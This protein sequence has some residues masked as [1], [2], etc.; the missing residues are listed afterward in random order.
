[1]HTRI[2]RI[3]LLLIVVSACLT[4]FAQNVVVSQDIELR[5]D[6]RYELFAGAEG[7]VILYR[8]DPQKVLLDAFG[9]TLEEVW[10]RELQLDKGRPKPLG[11]VV[12]E[13]EVNV[14]YTY[15]KDRSLQLKMHRYSAR[16]NMTDS[17]TIMELK[18]DFAN[19]NYL[20]QTD[21]K[22]QYA[23]LSI[24][25]D[26]N[27]YAM[28]GIEIATGRVLYQQKIDLSSE[29][30]VMRDFSEV[31]I[32][33]FGGAYLWSQENNRRSRLDEHVVRV[34]RVAV[35]GEVSTVTVAMPDLLLYD[36]Q[37]K[38][39]PRNKRIVGAGY[40]SINTDEAA[41]VI[42]V[43]L[44]YDMQ[45]AADI[46][47]AAFPQSVVTSV[48]P[49]SRKAQGVG[50]I[51]AMDVVF[52]RNGGVLLIGEQR[53]QTIRTVG[54]R[55][56]YFGG[57]IKTD[58]LYEDIILSSISPDSLFSWHEVLPKKQF[59]QD[60]GAAFSSYFLATTP[61]QL[62]LIYNDEVRSGGTVSQYTINGIGGIDRSSLMNTEYQD[63][64]LRH[65]AGVQ[66]SANS[67]VIPSER[68]NKLRLVKVLF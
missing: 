22:H 40:Y 60:D 66:V 36:F 20:L 59:S 5:S 27:T 41:G 28:I 39:D 49:R 53:K 34:V 21:A 67:I 63:L 54:G 26:V 24:Q 56:G 15:R 7:Q 47:T 45:G 18:D 57:T 11:A 10:S 17:M 30:F 6:S 4:A 50:Y 48:D 14:F 65:E 33:D 61:R 19:P 31:Y 52:R 3:S 23:I 16:G 68:R 13:G 62:R 25:R 44:P 9:P 1:M 42:M 38:V 64:W 46:M 8:D 2:T 12:A 51:E 32:D 35:N 37:L 43:Q 58:Y 55:S 29:S